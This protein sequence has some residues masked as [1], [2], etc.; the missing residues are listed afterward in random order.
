[1]RIL[2]C[3]TVL[4]LNLELSSAQDNSKVTLLR[5]TLG[6]AGA[7]TH[8][9]NYSIQFSIG[10]HTPI[11][12]SNTKQNIGIQGFIQPYLLAGVSSFYTIQNEL[13]TFPN[14]FQQTINLQ[15]LHKNP[16]PIRVKIYSM[17]GNI[18]FQQTFAP[19]QHL[20]IKPGISVA[21]SYILH[22][23]DGRKV[24]QKILI[25]ETY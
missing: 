6:I 23:T 11:S 22:V 10:Q 16:L 8:E 19:S 12:I 25:M 1:M 5:S 24:Y 14:P 7:S 18:R 2:I 4:I 21:G 15:F 9:E 3:L 20:K 17:Q 13:K